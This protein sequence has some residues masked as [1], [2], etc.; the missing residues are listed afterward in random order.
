M[1]ELLKR[2]F[3]QFKLPEGFWGHVA[4]KIMAVSNRELNAWTVSILSI[5]P[6]D[7]V[8]EV[9]F[10]PGVAIELV[11]KQL[12]TGM[13]VGID[14]SPIM[15][16]QASKR[17][18]TAISLGKVELKQASIEHLPAFHEPFDK[19][20]TVNSLMFWPEPVTHLRQLGQHLKPGGILA[21]TFQP[22]NKG[23]T[24]QT[25]LE[26]GKTYTQYLKEAGFTDI[27]MQSI[28]LKPV[29]AVCVTGYKPE[30]TYKP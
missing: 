10:G 8:L 4:G 29:L 28:K 24:D 14:A 26:E 17:N 12:D 6:D 18:A 23:A 2:F 5:Q 16:Q 25:A 3:D 15:M 13:V 1:A 7:R 30:L 22:R 11:S 19:I 9:G 27:H 20:F 21:V